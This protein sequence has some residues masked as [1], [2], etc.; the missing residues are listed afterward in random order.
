MHKTILTVL[1]GLFWAV[2]AFAQT[3]HVVSTSPAQ[4]ELNVPVSTNISVTFDVDMDES[5]INNSTFVVNARS[6]GLHEGTIT[7]DGPSKT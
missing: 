3:P 7:Y 5:T 6:T 4:N 2:P 1:L